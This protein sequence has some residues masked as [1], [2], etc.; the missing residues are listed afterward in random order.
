MSERIANRIRCPFPDCSSAD[1]RVL[2]KY[3]RA[4]DCTI[5]RKHRCQECKRKFTSDQRVSRAA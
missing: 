5:V 1:T 3:Y 2:W 4:K